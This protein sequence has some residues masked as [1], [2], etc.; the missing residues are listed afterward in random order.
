MYNKGFNMENIKKL[1]YM[2]MELSSGYMQPKNS[3]LEGFDFLYYLKSSRLKYESKHEK[4]YL[5][6]FFIL[7]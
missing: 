5:K 3:C 1:S 4:L 6:N 7:F 2:D